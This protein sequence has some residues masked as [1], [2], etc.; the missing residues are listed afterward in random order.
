MTSAYGTE[1]RTYNVLGQLTGIS[2]PNVTIGYAIPTAGLNNGRTASMTVSGETNGD[3]WTTGSISLS[4][5]CL[6]Q[7]NEPKI[8]YAR[9]WASQTA[10]SFRF[11]D[12]HQPRSIGGESRQTRSRTRRQTGAP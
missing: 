8:G 1:S 5:A 9:T 4:G 7:G 6:Q 10:H 2:A 12:M 11:G 3:D